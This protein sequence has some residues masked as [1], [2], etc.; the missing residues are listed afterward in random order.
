MTDYFA[1]LDQPRRPWLDAAALKEKF[2]TRSAAVHPDRVHGAD[3]ATQQHAQQRYTEL[4][5]A[6]LCLRDPRERLRHLL[7]L[8]LGRKPGDLQEMPPALADLFLTL[9]RACQ[10]TDAFLARQAGVTSPLLRAQSF[11]QGQ[12]FTDRLTA[13]QADLQSRQD[14]LLARLEEL[15]RSWG[16]VVTEG[17]TRAALLA[18]LETLSR[19]LGFFSRWQG[20]IQERLLRL[21]L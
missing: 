11:A 9:S 20:Q 4:N 17:P 5:A 13:L 18:E 6:Y 10:E 12:D 2:L 7:E 3:E 15:D 16:Q 21:L 8:E 14:Q 19:W 1:L